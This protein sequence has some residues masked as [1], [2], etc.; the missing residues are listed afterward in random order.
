MSNFARVQ[1]FYPP[2][3]FLKASCSHIFQYTPQRKLYLN[4]FNSKTLILPFHRQTP[5]L[6]LTPNPDKPEEKS[7]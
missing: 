5:F 2:K 7:L 6:R 3:R 1:H 4:I